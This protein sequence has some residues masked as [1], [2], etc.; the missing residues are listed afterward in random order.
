MPTSIPISTS[1]IETSLGIVYLAASEKGLTH[2]SFNK[3]EIPKPSTEGDEKIATAI[4]RNSAPTL[5]K[6]FDSKK[7]D[8]NK[9]KL[10]TRGTDFQE[11]TWKALRAIPHGSTKSYSQVAKS[12]GKPLAVRAVASACAKNP[13]LI[14]T[15]CH[16]VL[17]NDGS[18]GGFRGG[19]S[20]KKQ[21]LSL[22]E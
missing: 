16:R 1:Q 10:D 22:E 4:L 6:Y 11:K 17:R 12:I 13:L 18:L 5:K 20:K 7:A 19:I 14:V 9:L 21:L 8:L 3:S 15:P 2:V